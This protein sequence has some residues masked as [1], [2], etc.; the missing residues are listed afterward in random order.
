MEY[1]YK[2]GFYRAGAHCPVDEF[3]ESKGSAGKAKIDFYMDLLREKGPGLK[4]PYAAYLRDK[5]WEL[6]PGINTGEYRLFYFWYYKS[7][8]FVHA[9]DKK[10]FKQRDIDKAITR[11]T[12]IL[13]YLREKETQHE[14][15]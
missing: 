10:D 14:E 6:R 3:I 13:P 12:S 1:N 15:K 11:M 9:V 4:R 5:I 2:T 8:I 7:A